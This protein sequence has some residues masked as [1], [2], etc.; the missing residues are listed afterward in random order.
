MW[1]KSAVLTVDRSLP[2]YPDQRTF[3]ERS[4]MSQ[5][6]HQATYAKFATN[7]GHRCWAFK[8]DSRRPPI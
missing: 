2:V 3:Q 7:N 8:V 6:C 4:G 5:R 1:V